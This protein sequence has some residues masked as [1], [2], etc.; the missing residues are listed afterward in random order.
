[1]Q[2]V[3]TSD[4]SSLHAKFVEFLFPKGQTASLVPQMV[5]SPSRLLTDWLKA[6]IAKE[7]GV[8]MGIHFLLPQDF[9]HLVSQTAN[10]SNKNEQNPWSAEVLCWRILPLLEKYA[11]HLGAENFTPGGRDALVLARKLADQFDQYAHFRPEWICSWMEDKNVLPPSSSLQETW[12][13][14]LWKQLADAIEEDFSTQPPA[15]VLAKAENDPLFLEKIK[16]SLPRLAVIGVGSLDPF[17]VRILKILDKAG[18]DLSV[19]VALPSLHF[20]GDLQKNNIAFHLNKGQD[21]DDLE[22]PDTHPLLNSM[23]KHAVGAFLL[24]GELDENYTAW[25]AE[26]ELVPPASASSHLLSRVQTDIRSLINRGFSPVSPTVFRFDPEND[27]SIR[28]HSCHGPRREMEVLR[29]ELFRAFAEIPGLTPDQ[30]VIVSP[31]LETYTPLVRSVFPKEKG[32]PVFLTELPAAEQDPYIEAVLELLAVSQGRAC[33]SDLLSLLRLRAIRACLGCDEEE[34]LEKLESWIRSSG[35]TEWLDAD[36]RKQAGFSSDNTGTW[37][38]GSD[39]LIAGHWLGT[40]KNAKAQTSETFLLPVCGELDGGGTLK[41][42]FLAWLENLVSVL[43]EWKTPATAEKWADRFQG[44]VENV[45]SPANNSIEVPPNLSAVFFLREMDSEVEMESG[46]ML[47][48]LQEQAT[49]S[50]R[51]GKIAGG[52]AFGRLKQLQCIPCRVLVLV[53]MEERNFPSKNQKLAWDL[54]QE[55]PKVWDR[56]PRSDDRQ[57]FLDAILTPSERL[58]LT[59]STR[60]IRTGKDEPFSSCV[61]E[62]LAVLAPLTAPGHPMTNLVFK[63]RILPIA[64][65]YFLKTSTQSFSEEDCKMAEILRENTKD[66]AAPFIG[67]GVSLDCPPSPSISISALADFWKN[68]A[69]AFLRAQS[70]SQPEDIQEETKF[71][72][73]PLALDNL[74]KWKIRD[75]ILRA[76]LTDQNS[77][78]LQAS[79]EGNRQLPLE[80]LGNQVWKTNF[81]SVATLAK[82]IRKVLPSPQEK[83]SSVD[84]RFPSDNEN[85]VQI[86]GSLPL[87][88]TG[89][90]TVLLSYR[91]GKMKKPK[92]LLLPWIRAVIASASGNLLPSYLVADDF[93]DGTRIEPLPMETALESLKFLL[94]GYQEGLKRPLCFAPMTSHVLSK[95]GGNFD[96]AKQEWAKEEGLQ[97]ETLLVWRDLDPFAAPSDTDW[98]KWGEKIA[99]SLYSWMPFDQKN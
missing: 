50:L 40:E 5:V 31:S 60:N 43:R 78:F 11:P 41:K 63:H 13:R 92:H 37:L 70:I 55:K 39:R 54:L 90:E 83:D 96:K 80:H 21:I 28:I 84:F 95:S 33:A 23:G 57:L 53:G 17:L 87:G 65:D 85:A 26:G 73:H 48:W 98:T 29:D 82:T 58:I 12:Q 62:L 97:P 16:A 46:A 27:R 32:L 49:A 45:L 59:G 72:R 51:K 94:E 52:I 89:D 66:N 61:D 91:C 18:C 3:P 4:L 68:P 42:T 56:N 71:D 9:I 7:K 76:I 35:I 14:E 79:L 20:L 88:K 99:L 2:I 1:M 30:I 67:K 69:K 81:S 47:D 22:L 34:K 77:A 44:Y 19:Y 15:V 25:P 64:E 86:F 93:P 8:C 6:S 38:F 36:A 24:L 10:P 75:E 74:Q